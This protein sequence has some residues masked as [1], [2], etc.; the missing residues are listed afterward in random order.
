[1]DKPKLSKILIIVLCVGA[2]LFSACSDSSSKKTTSPPDETSD[3][4][5]NSEM[6]VRLSS[7]LT[8]SLTSE[9]VG[10]SRSQAETISDAGQ[11][12][13]DGI[14]LSS[15][16]TKAGSA[17]EVQ[18]VPQNFI[19]GAMAA[20]DEA[21]ISDMLKVKVAGVIMESPVKDL[22]GELDD[23]T[24]AEAQELMGEM[25]NAAIENL[26]E[27]GMGSKSPLAIKMIMSKG[28]G[29]LDD[30]GFTAENV[31]GVLQQMN[32]GA[33]SALNEADIEG[34]LAET[35]LM[36]ITAGSV[37]ALGELDDMSGFDT[38][39]VIESVKYITTGATGALD[40]AGFADA[41]AINNALA[42]LS[43][44]AT[45]A[46]DDAG[47]QGDFL[48]TALG[49]ITAGSV[50]ALD[51]IDITGF[52][53]AQI[54]SAVSFISSGV[55][56]ALD[57]TGITPAQIPDAL[58]FLNEEAVGA[59]ADI[60]DIE[61]FDAIMSTAV[62]NIASG[63]IGALD[64]IHGLVE[65]QLVG[66]AQWVTAGTALG[67]DDVGIAEA[68]M[69]G[70]IEAI[71]TASVGALGLAGIPADLID[72][73]AL[74]MTDSLYDSL[75]D[76]GFD[77]T[78][79]ALMLDDIQLAIN[80]GFAYIDDDMVQGDWG[81]AMA[82][83]ESAITAYDGTYDDPY[84]DFFACV[85]AN[86]PGCGM[87]MCGDM[88]TEN[89]C[90]SAI[91]CVWDTAGDSDECLEDYMVGGAAAG[92]ICY[93]IETAGECSSID[94]C[95]W[96]MAGFCMESA[97]SFC[98]MFAV[99][100]ECDFMPECAWSGTECSENM[101]WESSSCADLLTEDACIMATLMG[102]S[103][104][105]STLMCDGTGMMTTC[106]DMTSQTECVSNTA[107][108][109]G[110]EWDGSFCY[111][112]MGDGDICASFPLE[113]DCMMADSVGCYWDGSACIN[114][115]GA[116]MDP[117]MCESYMTRPECD[118]SPTELSCTWLEAY[119][120]CSSGSSGGD[121][122]FVLCSDVASQ[123]ECIETTNSFG[124]GCVWS[125]TSCQDGDAG[126]T[127]AMC[128][129]INNQADC[130]NAFMMYGLDCSWASDMCGEGTGEIPDIPG[131][132]MDLLTEEDCYTSDVYGLSCAWDAG[133]C[134]EDIGGGGGSSPSSCMDILIQ[135]EC[136]AA[137]TNYMLD[138]AWSGS[139]CEDSG[140]GG[141]GED[142][143]T[144]GEITGESECDTAMS[145]YSLDCAWNVSVC[146]D[147]G[148][149]GEDPTTCGEITGESECDTAMSM[150]LL[151]CAW[152][153]SVCEDNGGGMPFSCTELSQSECAIYSLDCYWDSQGEYCDEILAK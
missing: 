148:G 145:M 111:L 82:A 112:G 52:E 117:N 102:C 48:E 139:M 132:C 5:Q 40:D 127:P 55:T 20:I 94:V 30:A 74:G 77:A 129:D 24:D 18:V 49:N 91:G 124:F 84:A 69:L 12:E 115:A 153:V 53:A 7:S 140:G 105:E 45:G 28:V 90:M 113:L 4:P 106:E 68:D 123:A 34:N 15:G 85:D 114:G 134:A 120:I 66:C 41:D 59:L 32:A 151:D 141:G 146:E 38:G 75:D 116:Y 60:D 46:L 3:D 27:G 126:N 88:S 86:D 73:A 57:D 9:S 35:A 36:N 70:Y 23:L 149:G 2:V 110:C 62:S 11:G 65:D 76:I 144:C 133:L 95:A 128:F 125:S 26:N 93:M 1:M 96:D 67:L 63:S 47:L 10:V 109:L 89:D 135:T 44:G 16:L 78:D 97:G 43:A 58:K 56:S 152:N 64:D 143:T 104:S 13:A 37:A 33:V 100:S 99:Q 25:S 118:A 122:T 147:N 107:L 150:Y 92:E 31:M 136:E 137:M 83:A 50:A 29:A 72:N 79:A 19:K 80:D 103:W 21:D 108:M 142:P 61:G 39:D 101:T 98:T 51:E 131:M 81:A 22:S 42:K 71:S 17:S 87:V 54:A 119:N 6:A 121:D 130:D 8:E 14:Y 138:C